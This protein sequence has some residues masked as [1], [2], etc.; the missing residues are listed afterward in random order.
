MGYVKGKTR[1][2]K[3]VFISARITDSY[4]TDYYAIHDVIKRGKRK[5]ELT[6]IQAWVSTSNIQLVKVI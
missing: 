4:G 2:G 1:A 5:G 3:I 6:G